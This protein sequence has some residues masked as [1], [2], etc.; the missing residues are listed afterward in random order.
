[1]AQTVE[2]ISRQLADVLRRLDDQDR[3][4]DKRREEDDRRE[5]SAAAAREALLTRVDEHG[6]RTTKLE[7]KWEAFFGD[8]G[9]FRLFCSQISNHDKKL[10]RLTMY[11]FIGMGILIAAQ[12]FIPML[13][14]GK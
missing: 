9:A 1:M 2:G 12:F 8:Q 5:A 4:Y 10:D 3:K 13:L 11:F 7:T 6:K 14:K